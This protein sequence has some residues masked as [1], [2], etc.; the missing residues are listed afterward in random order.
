MASGQQFLTIHSSF[1]H[2][3]VVRL[4]RRDLVQLISVVAHLVKAVKVLYQVESAKTRK[5]RLF[6]VSD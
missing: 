4:L 1:P 5:F 6:L 2:F 3:V